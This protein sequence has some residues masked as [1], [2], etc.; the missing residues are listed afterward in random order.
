MPDPA[1][2]CFDHADQRW[3]TEWPEADHHDW[4][5]FRVNDGLGRELVERAAARRPDGSAAELVLDP[6]AY[7]FD[8]QLAASAALR[9]RSGWLRAIKAS[10]P[11]GSTVREELLVAAFDDAGSTVPQAV[12]DSLMFAPAR[13]VG[14]TTQALPAEALE[15]ASDGVRR[16]FDERVRTENFAWVEAEEAR[17]D[18]YARDLEIE[19]DA[20]IA[21]KEEEIRLK[22]R[23]GRAATLAMEDKLALSRAVKKLEAEADDLKM[24][25]FDA[26]RK[27]R[28]DVEDKLDAFA[29]SLARAASFTPV[30]TLRWSVV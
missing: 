12:A 24:S 13:S 16:G 22:R 2:E 27:A 23:E 14:S 1:G 17:L 5:F 28:R 7:P 6:A 18:A 29:E 30:L 20:Q 19:L 4:Q 3:T 26:R 25:K 8:G 15:A 9:G 21:E 10:I 11:T